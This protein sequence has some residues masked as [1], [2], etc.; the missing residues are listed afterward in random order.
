MEPYKRVV[1]NLTGL[2]LSQNYW[3]SSIGHAKLR[4]FFSCLSYT[5]HFNA[6]SKGPSSGRLNDYLLLVIL[7]AGLVMGFP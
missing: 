6:P 7:S 2:A 1:L 4:D 5:P 3:D